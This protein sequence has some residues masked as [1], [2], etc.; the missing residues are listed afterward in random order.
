MKITHK[1]ILILNFCQSVLINKEKSLIE[2]FNKTK[3][4]NVQLSYREMLEK[5]L[6]E[7][8]ENGSSDFQ[9]KNLQSQLTEEIMNERIQMI[10]NTETLSELS[11]TI[12]DIQNGNIQ[13]RT[14]DQI[15]MISSFKVQPIQEDSEHQISDINDKHDDT[16][17]DINQ[18]L[19]HDHPQNLLDSAEI[20]GQDKHEQNIIANP[21]KSLNQSGFAMLSP[22]MGLRK[23]KAKSENSL[24]NES[25]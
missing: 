7:A 1:I 13:P 6:K 23:S 17:E 21:D 20:I 8:I 11:R 4:K 2:I 14:T 12:D 22:K 15:N 5:R 3:E 10:E 16:I 24:E 18:D 19:N 9:V 25:D